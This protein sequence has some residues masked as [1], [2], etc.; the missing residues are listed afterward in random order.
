VA[1]GDADKEGL[2]RQFKDFVMQGN[3]V[4]LAV[5]VVMGLA[6]EAVVKAFVTDILTPIIGIFGKVN[7]ENLHATVRGSTFYYGDVLNYIVTFI[8]VAAAVFFLVV[9]PYEH[10]QRTQPAT[11]KPCPACTTDIPI[12]ATRCPAC[13]TELPAP[14]SS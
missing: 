11:T 7:F 8:F 9:K 3:V 2:F 5:A 1:D 10:F 12:D 4:M 6:F 14:A 13:T